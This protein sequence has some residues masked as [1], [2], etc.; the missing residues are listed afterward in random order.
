MSGGKGFRN[1]AFLALALA[2]T[3]ALVLVLLNLTA[4]RSPRLQAEPRIPL[5]DVMPLV[6][7]DMKRLVE[8]TGRVIPARRLT[9]E[10][11]VSGRVIDK[12]P[13]LYAGGTLMAGETLFAIDPTDYRIV[14]AQAEAALAQAE[15]AVEI[16]RGRQVIARQEL[17][18]LMG[19]LPEAAVNQ[20]LA[21]RAPQLRQVMAEAEEA[22]AAVDNAAL[23]LERTVVTAP[24][25]A[26]VLS[27]SV[28]PGQLVQS[29]ETAAELAATDAYW[30]NVQ[31][32]VPLLPM[33]AVGADGSEADVRLAATDA[34]SAN[35][36]WTGQVIRRLGALSKDSRLATVVVEVRHPLETATANVP[37]LLD[38]FV[39]VSIAGAQLNGV[40]EV[41]VMALRE[42]D[43]VWVADADDMLRY[44]TVT[45]TWRRTETV[46][47]RGDFEPG[48][49][50]IVSRLPNV[51]PGIK[52]RISDDTADS[53]SPQ[54]RD[55]NAGVNPT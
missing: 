32:P 27:A 12:H 22:R 31:V 51:L 20:S 21:L 53:G 30:I 9:M 11:Q 28:E 15:A 36:G 55:T 33:I 38:S 23:D 48:D 40:Y 3:T 16:E 8:G 24:F 29:G 18:L 35:N 19:D 50:L 43:Q 34:V 39:R 49:R 46:V 54:V 37:L 13:A 45:V 14:L 44:R 41:P 25:D 17:D 4:P 52:L 2:G 6:A 47:V 7:K 26:L 1:P 42:G 5:V 10:P